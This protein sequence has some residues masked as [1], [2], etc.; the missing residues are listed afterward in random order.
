GETLGERVRRCG[1][2]S[3]DQALVLVGQM[4]AGLG[5]AHDAAVVH[6]DFKSDNVMLVRPRASFGS[7]R[8]VVTDF[9]LARAGNTGAGLLSAAGAMIGSPMYMAPEQ[10]A[11]GEVGPAADLYALGVVMFEMLTGRLPFTADTPLGAALKRLEQ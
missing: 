2:I 1:P 10:V 5:A 4:A 9:G 11:G 8:A 3:P 7:E 6:R